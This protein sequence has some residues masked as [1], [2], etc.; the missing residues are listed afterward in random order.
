MNIWSK[1]FIYTNMHYICVFVLHIKADPESTA[2]VRDMNICSVIFILN[3][4]TLHFRKLSKF[5]N[6]N[7]ESQWHYV[8]IKNI[9]D[10]YVVLSMRQSVKAC[11]Q[12]ALPT[13]LNL[14]G[15]ALHSGSCPPSFDKSIAKVLLFNKI[16]IMLLHCNWTVNSVQVYYN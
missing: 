8:F 10:L 12:I 16:L 7:I 4:I 1:K 11:L 9:F 2:I 5:L 13:V 15:I 14:R 6:F 3:L